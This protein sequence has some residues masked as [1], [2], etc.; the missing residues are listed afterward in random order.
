[1]SLSWSPVEQRELD[2][3]DQIEKGLGICCL[4][5]RRYICIYSLAPILIGQGLLHQVF[6]PLHLLVGTCSR[7]DKC[8]FQVQPARRWKARN[9]SSWE[10]TLPGTPARTDWV[11]RSW[12]EQEDKV[13]VKWVK[14]ES[15]SFYR[16][17]ITAQGLEEKHL[18]KDDRPH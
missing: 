4:W 5:E 8:A 14:K 17:M 9:A 6:T 15:N 12:N 10:R 1:M 2:H 11:N 13:S 3:Q 16:K 7:K 18:M